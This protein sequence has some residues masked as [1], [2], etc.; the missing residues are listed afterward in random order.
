MLRVNAYTCGITLETFVLFHSYSLGI[1]KT[2]RLDVVLFCATRKTQCDQTFLPFFFQCL[3]EIYPTQEVT[4]R[5]HAVSMPEKQAY[6]WFSV[7]TEAHCAM[8][9]TTNALL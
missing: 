8:L 7:N 4:H 9:E 5:P 6:T 3:S 1:S 2:S